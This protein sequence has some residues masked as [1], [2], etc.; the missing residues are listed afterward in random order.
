MEN[1]TFSLENANKKFTTPQEELEFLREKVAKQERESSN[2][3]QAPKEENISRQIHEYKKEK[4]EA[5]LEES[6]KLPEKKE[7]EIVL[8]L[9]P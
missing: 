2:I 3:E 1:P 6:Y 5:V 9:S 4:P 7:N 8:K